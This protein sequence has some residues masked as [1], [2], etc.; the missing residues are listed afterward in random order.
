M[1]ELNLISGQEQRPPPVGQ[2]RGPA[3]WNAD[4]LSLPEFLWTGSY[5]LPIIQQPHFFSVYSSEIFGS[6]LFS[7]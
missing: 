7:N 6:S 4:G 2:V 3:G 5:S 1:A